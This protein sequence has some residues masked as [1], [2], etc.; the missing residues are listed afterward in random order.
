MRPLELNRQG[1]ASRDH[2]F[3]ARDDRAW[4]VMRAHF[5]REAERERERQD[6]ERRSAF[7]LA[8]AP[9]IYPDVEECRYMIQRYHPDRPD[10]DR[11]KFEK[12]QQLLDLAKRASPG[13]VC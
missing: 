12:W 7:G 9:S 13:H 1:W 5:E 2:L 3:I 11:E 6:R 4:A 10:G 8:V